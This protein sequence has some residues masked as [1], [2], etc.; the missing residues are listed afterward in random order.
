MISSTNLKQAGLKPTYARM[1]ILAIFSSSDSGHLTA[2]EIRQTLANDGE[3]VSMATVYRVLTQFE[4]AGILERHKLN[5]GKVVF[6]L[7]QKE[8]HDHLVCIQCGK[9]IEFKDREIEER[10]QAIAQEKGFVLKDHV[11]QLFVEC[12]DPKCPNKQAV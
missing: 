4:T 2:E 3:D 7:N 8:H 9:W 6:E 11:L 1:C 10:Q 12:T 5:D